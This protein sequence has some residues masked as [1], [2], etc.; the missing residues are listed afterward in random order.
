MARAY[1]DDLRRKL[2]EAHQDGEGTLEELAEQF[3]VSAAWARK[4]SACL[5]RTGKM[6]RPAG[7]QRGRKSKVTAEVEEFLKAA[8]SGQSDLTL[9]ELQ[10]RLFKERKLEISIGWLWHTLER[11]GLHL[12]KNAS[13]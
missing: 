8:A 10:L 11:L 4:I 9:A 3:R 7:K 13:R 12:K 1:S 5:H 6:E 2:L